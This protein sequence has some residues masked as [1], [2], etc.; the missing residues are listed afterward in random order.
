MWYFL[1]GLGLGLIGL[2]AVYQTVVKEL[3]SQLQYLIEENQRLIGENE[4]LTQ[5]VDEITPLKIEVE[6]L[7]YAEERVDRL[8]ARPSTVAPSL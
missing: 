2:L 3:N 6:K 7:R 4:S 5:A 1:A 8:F